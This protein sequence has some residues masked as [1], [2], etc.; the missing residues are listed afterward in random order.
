MAIGALKTAL[1]TGGGG[2]GIG[3]AIARCC[4]MEGMS[5]VLADIHRERLDA[6]VAAFDG[7]VMGVAMD[8][9]KIQHWTR[10]RQEAETRFG[11]VDLLV[12]SAGIA[13]SMASI[14]DMAVADFDARI[15]I[16]LSSVFYGVRMFGPA[17]R[18]RAIAIS[19]TSPRKPAW[20]R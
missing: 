5:V 13:P 16:N 2:S 3:L 14:L 20:C 15:R 10:A 4:M 7:A 11:A 19:S 1:I 17:M 6:A 9:S 8:V 12:N 18:A